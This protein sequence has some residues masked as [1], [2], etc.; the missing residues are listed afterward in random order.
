MPIPSTSGTSTSFSSQIDSIPS[1]TECKPDSIFFLTHEIQCQNPRG[2]KMS[3][4]GFRQERWYPLLHPFPSQN[5]KMNK[6]HEKTIFHRINET[7]GKKYVCRCIAIC[8]CTQ[9]CDSK[10]LSIK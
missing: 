2:R 1:D 9:L 7:Q 6:G 3:G 4:G 8:V 10:H 5:L